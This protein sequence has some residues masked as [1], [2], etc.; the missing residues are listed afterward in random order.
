MVGLELLFCESAYER[1]CRGTCPPMTDECVW[2]RVHLGLSH[3]ST[4]GPPPLIVILFFLALLSPSVS[5]LNCYFDAQVILGLQPCEEQ[6]M[7]CVA[8]HT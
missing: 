8:D 3:L 6:L 4:C 1:V 5:F 7:Q 2:S